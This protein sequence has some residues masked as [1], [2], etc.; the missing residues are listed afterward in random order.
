MADPSQVSVASVVSVSQ[1]DPDDRQPLVIL[2]VG[3]EE[4][5]F[6]V[7]AAVQ[8]AFDVFRAADA[9]IFTYTADR[10][11]DELGIEETAKQFFVTELLRRSG[12]GPP[13]DMPAQ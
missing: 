9:G 11:L 5:A 4:A 3:S 12:G 7:E 2:K 10:L 6:S 1:T 8:F 13:P